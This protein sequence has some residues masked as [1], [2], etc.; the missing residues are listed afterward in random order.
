M[1]VNMDEDLYGEQ[2]PGFF[3]TYIEYINKANKYQISEG[4]NEND[5]IL[6]LVTCIQHQP[7][8][9][10]IV[11]AKETGRTLYN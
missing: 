1:R 7:Q 2:D 9:R 10:Q 3:K 8:Y 5:K 4:L 11:I 6:T